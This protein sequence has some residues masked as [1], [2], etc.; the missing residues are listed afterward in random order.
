MQ[1]GHDV[2]SYRFV[3]AHVAQIPEAVAVASADD[4][5]LVI[6]FLQDTCVTFP[7]VK[8]LHVVVFVIVA[9][10]NRENL[11]LSRVNLAAHIP[12]YDVIPFILTEKCIESESKP[13]K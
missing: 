7:L 8:Y 3:C 1:C 13:S 10:T 11:S 4:V 5:D 9:H 6:L 12:F 2:S